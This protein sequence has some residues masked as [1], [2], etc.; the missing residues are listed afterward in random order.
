MP[1]YIYTNRII[2]V[3]KPRRMRWVGN[4]EHMGERRGA[5]GVSVGKPKGKTRLGKSRHSCEDNIQMGL[6]KIR[7]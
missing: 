1:V 6:K 2:R 4:M 7:C 3:I 5:Y